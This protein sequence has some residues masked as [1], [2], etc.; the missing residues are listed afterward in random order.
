MTLKY[1]VDHGQS[2]GTVALQLGEKFKAF[3]KDLLD[4]IAP[5]LCERRP[6]P[7]LTMVDLQAGVKPDARLT[8]KAGR[9]QGQKLHTNLALRKKRSHSRTSLAPFKRCKPLENRS[10]TGRKGSTGA[11][12]AEVPTFGEE[13]CSDS[14]EDDTDDSDPEDGVVVLEDITEMV[15]VDNRERIGEFYVDALKQIG[16]TF[17]KRIMKAWIIV[18]HPG[19]QSTFPYNGGLSKRQLTGDVAAQGIDKEN[20]G[21]YTR[22]PWWCTQ[23]NWL[24][25]KGCRHKEPDHLRKPERLFFMP[26]ILRFTGMT[27]HPQMPT[28]DVLR[29]STELFDM[30]PEQREALDTMYHVREKEQQ[31]E[32]GGMDGDSYIYVPKPKPK[33]RPARKKNG[34][35][36]MPSDRNGPRRERYSSIHSLEEWTQ[37]Q[38]SS[39]MGSLDPSYT[40]VQS[41]AVKVEDQR[42]FEYPGV[43]HAPGFEHPENPFANVYSPMLTNPDMQSHDMFAPD[44]HLGRDTMIM[45]PPSLIP[46]FGGRSNGCATQPVASTEGNRG[47]Q[48]PR[49]I[50]PRPRRPTSVPKQQTTSSYANGWPCTFKQYDFIDDTCAL[51]GGFRKTQ[52]SAGRPLQGPP[53]DITS[54]RHHA[55]GLPLHEQERVCATFGCPNSHT[56]DRREEPWIQAANC[57]RYHCHPSRHDD[58]NFYG[59]HAAMQLPYQ[60]EYHPSLHGD[61]TH[62]GRT[63]MQLPTQQDAASSIDLDALMATNR[64]FF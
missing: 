16:Q 14:G 19:K 44:A 48:L 1:T 7:L 28:V 46:P 62:D 55:H 54:D 12:R 27:E 6:S 22:P 63:A 18:K 40:S 11:V 9:V 51:G 53:I 25:G 60:Q 39:A 59:G 13:A 26:I 2:Q 3:E 42:R 35:L 43:I 47:R 38:P 29:K 49:Q 58:E 41:P 24:Q 32:D 57:A 8:P 34:G 56:I 23:E 5:V 15:R 52:T 31:F 61:D 10:R 17:G 21:K 30:R 50:E 36:T 37:A 20:P 45:A 4:A 33:S 64:S